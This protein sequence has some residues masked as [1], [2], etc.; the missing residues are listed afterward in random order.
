MREIITGQAAQ[1]HI[2]LTFK[3]IANGGLRPSSMTAV[4]P[5]W[6]STVA[7]PIPDAWPLDIPFL[8]TSSPLV[9]VVLESEFDI[10]SAC[11]LGPVLDLSDG[12]ITDHKFSLFFSSPPPEFPF[13]CSEQK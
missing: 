4:F 13:G 6:I 8:A 3:T 5:S 1:V 7:C 11:A 9:F 12:A 2:C 10:A